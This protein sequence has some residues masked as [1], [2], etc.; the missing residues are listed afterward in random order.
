MYIG[1]YYHAVS[2]LTLKTS[3]NW[4]S[5]YDTSHCSCERLDGRAQVSREYWGFQ[6]FKR[7]KCISWR[8]HVTCQSGNICL[9]RGCLLQRCLS[10]MLKPHAWSLFFLLPH[11]V[12]VPQISI[13]Q[14]LK[15]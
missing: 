15:E 11:L 10:D 5:R 4:S 9:S 3:Y 1:F 6:T 7:S 14:R 12:Q 8:I 2:F 13:R